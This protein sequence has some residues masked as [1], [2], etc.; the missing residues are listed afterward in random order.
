MSQ[1][2][3]KRSR[4]ARPS[5]PSVELERPLIRFNG[6]TDRLLRYRLL[7]RA[8][9]IGRDVLIVVNGHNTCVLLHKETSVSE[10]KDF[11]Q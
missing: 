7:E 6:N 11:C 4:G 8:F 2:Q 9:R 1:D 10:H 3:Q 5:Y